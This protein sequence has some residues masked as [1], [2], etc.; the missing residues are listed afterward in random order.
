MKSF[1]LDTDSIKDFIDS[2][3][4]I[5]VAVAIVGLSAYFGWFNATS[6]PI[7]V[8]LG[9]IYL[10]YVLRGSLTQNLLSRYPNATHI[11]LLSIGIC[12]ASLGVFAR[13][14]FPSLQSGVLDCTWIS[15]SFTTI[16]AFVIINRRNKDVL[17]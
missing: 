4:A 9:G 11:S 10:G 7:L 2:W 12:T 6:H 13:M 5:L 15:I 1:Q 8:A 3:P 16:L 14:M 17:Q